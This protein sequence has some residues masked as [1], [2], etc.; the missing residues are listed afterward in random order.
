[1]STGV[2]CLQAAPLPTGRASIPRWKKATRYERLVEGNRALVNLDPEHGAELAKSFLQGYYRAKLDRHQKQVAKN[3]ARIADKQARLDA[4]LRIEVA[5]AAQPRFAEAPHS[6]SNPEMPAFWKLVARLGKGAPLRGLRI[7]GIQHLLGT[8]GGLMR[9]LADSG[10]APSDVAFIG[11]TYSQHE[12][13]A[14][15]LQKDGFPVH[16][17]DFESSLDVK[18]GVTGPST[19]SAKNRPAE[20]LNRLDE[21]FELEDVRSIEKLRDAVR[22]G[23]APKGRK[24]LLIDDGGELIEL[25]HH[26]F[27][28]LHDRIVA[29]EQTTK[30]KKR[31]EALGLAFPVVDVAGSEAKRVWESP[32]IGR[33]VAKTTLAKLDG[34]KRQGVN[35]GK[36][37]LVIGFGAVGRATAL[38]LREQGYEVSVVDSRPEMIGEATGAG[39]GTH[40]SLDAALPHA[41]IV[42]G[43][44]GGSGLAAEQ[45]AK[46][47]SG[48]VLI[49]AA[50]SA[51]EFVPK[52]SEIVQHWDSRLWPKWNGKAIVT[53]FQGK[54]FAMGPMKDLLQF[55]KAPARQD[56]V[57]R[58]AGGKELLLVNQGQVIN[59]DGS[60]DPIPARY[61][62][63]TRGLLY[64]AAVQ[65]AKLPAGSKGMVELDRTMAKE[66]VEEVKADLA[67]TNES[68][69]HPSF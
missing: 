47:P 20:L 23:K 49:N 15:E 11:K 55:G 33:S 69:E 12:D 61:I 58:V 10:A 4:K 13:V 51:T 21:L 60:V 7:A 2:T 68:L 46:L 9:G 1:M 26:H 52:M 65:A 66:W 64:I 36:K 31:V 18:F 57:L 45:L 14:A 37:V 24:F 34:L 56:W 8:T 5:A 50:S 43:A 3:G 42:I 62:Q 41:E 32:M 53:S 59:F 27:P 6:V 30:G 38:A 19:G 25:V 29:V 39:F 17:S 16:L 67:R 28:E 22:A 44:T 63:L 48:A 35:V 54:E 40:A